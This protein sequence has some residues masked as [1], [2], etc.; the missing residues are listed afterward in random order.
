MDLTNIPFLDNNEVKDKK[1]ILRVDFNVTQNP[2]HS[3][4]NDARIQQSMPTIRHLLKNGNKLIII[5]HLNRPKQRDEAHS[6]QVV[7]DRLGELLPENEM[8]LVDDFQTDDKSVFNNQTPNQ[9]LVIENI[10]YYPEERNLGDGSFS[11]ELAALG[12]VYV[13]DAFGVCHRTDS[14]V[15]GIPKFL[16]SYGGLLLKREIEMISASISSPQSPVTAILGGAKISSKINLI[17]SFMDF[18]DHI[19]IGGGLANTFLAAQGYNIAESFYEYDEVEKAKRILF[20]AAQKNTAIQLPYDVI[21]GS[22][23]IEDH[24]EYVKSVAKMDEQDE[25]IL[26]I[27]PETQARYGAIIAKS[28]TVIW[29][30]PMGYIEKD[31]FKRGTDFIYYSIANNKEAMT[32][33]GGGDTLSAISK[34]EYLENIDHIST[35]GGAMLEF[36][37][38]RTLPGI[39]ALMN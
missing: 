15:C 27:G 21:I 28:S 17:A 2:D 22:L 30:G 32:V 11:K 39:E 37:E 23:E 36:V 4:A 25:M 14:S 34:K 19:L 18:A 26:D 1:V 6:L 29:N 16:P 8:I 20:E 31:E 12:E 5:S 7:A 10:R 9:V 3:I 35:G 38:K 24:E 33:V 13:N